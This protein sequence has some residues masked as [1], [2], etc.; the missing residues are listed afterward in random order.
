MASKKYSL[1]TCVMF[2]LASYGFSQTTTTPMGTSY[3]ASDSSIIP[4]R[5]MPQHTE[6]MNGTYNY[7]AK[8]RNMW[9]VG[10]KGGLSTISGDV[11]SRAAIGYGAHIRKAFGYLFSARISYMEG[12]PKGLNWQRSAN[13]RLNPAWADRYSATAGVPVFTTTKPNYVIWP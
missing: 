13:Y 7:P 11:T 5:S 6:F 10:I 3:D 1:L 8:P 2:L 4:S 9:E 12:S